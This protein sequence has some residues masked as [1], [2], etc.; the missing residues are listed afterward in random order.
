MN[1]AQKE[2]LVTETGE[3]VIQLLQN[4]RRVTIGNIVDLLEG[5]RHAASGERAEHLRAV[6]VFIRKKAVL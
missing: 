4:T 6:L 5:K 3:A 2:I 1:T